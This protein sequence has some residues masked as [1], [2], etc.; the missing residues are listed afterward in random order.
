MDG[1]EKAYSWCAHSLVLV[2]LCWLGLGRGFKPCVVLVVPQLVE[3]GL[4]IILSPWQHGLRIHASL[5]KQNLVSLGSNRSGGVWRGEE[6]LTSM[7]Q[8]SEGA[9]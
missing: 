7:A 2:V 6:V 5:W 8:F 3:I 4:S 1:A 9:L